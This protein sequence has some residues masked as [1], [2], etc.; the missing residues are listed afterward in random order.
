DGLREQG[1]RADRG[2]KFV[3]H[4]RHEI[5]ADLF[6]PVPVGLVFGEHE[7]EA[8]A[9]DGAGQRCHPDREGGGPAAEARHGHLE[10]GLADLPV[11]TNLPGESG[12]LAHHEPVALD[13]PEGA[14][15]GA[16]PQHAVLA[17]DNDR[18][19]REYGKDRRDSRR[20]FGW[21]LCG[22]EPRIPRQPHSLPRARPHRHAVSLTCVDL[23]R[24]DRT[25]GCDQS[26]L[27]YLMVCAASG[28]TTIDGLPEISLF[29]G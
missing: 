6:D 25:R 22:P 1:K 18:G 10:L 23:Y 14:G 9:A 20:Q 29:S 27:T 5:P 28:A 17:V 8:P 21:L 13:D 15:G 3:A 4:V 12:P 26:I 2:L 19:G 24:P 7:H 11:P 16:G